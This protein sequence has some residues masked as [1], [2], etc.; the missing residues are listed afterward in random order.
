MAEEKS[1]N[2]HFPQYRDSLHKE[3]DQ[4]RGEDKNGNQ[5]GNKQ[6]EPDRYIFLSAPEQ[7]AVA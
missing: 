3:K 2:G 5:G 1:P 4:D 7:A 6:D